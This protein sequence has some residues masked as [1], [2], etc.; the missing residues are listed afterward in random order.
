M[1]PIGRNDSFLGPFED[2]RW[3]HFKEISNLFSGHQYLVQLLSHPP[4]CSV[5][6][7]SLGGGEVSNPVLPPRLP[8]T[9]FPLLIDKIGFTV[10]TVVTSYTSY[11]DKLLKRLGPPFLFVISRS[12]VQIPPPA[13]SLFAAGFWLV[14]KTSK[15]LRANNREFP[16]RFNFK[17]INTY[18]LVVIFLV[19]LDKLFH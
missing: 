12:R 6:I 13:P 19:T 16:F 14:W 3:T 15:I 11:F 17:F 1:N 4:V 5:K 7:D 18:V 10:L 9:I 2:C 8:P